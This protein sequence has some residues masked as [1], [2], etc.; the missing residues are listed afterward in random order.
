MA[1]K[2]LVHINGEPLDVE[3]NRDGEQITVRFGDE[4]TWHNVDLQ[5]VFASGLFVLLMD[6]RPI[7]L[8][9]E[10]G[11]RS[12]ARVTVGRHRFE[13]SVERWRPPS[14]RGRRRTLTKSGKIEIKA[15]M[16][17]SIVEVLCAVGDTLEEGDVVM[18]IE[19]M[20]MNN[21]QRS[22]VRGVVTSMRVK[23]GDRVQS[24]A[25]LAELEAIPDEGQETAD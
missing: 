18:V 19:S 2:H 16:T 21:E 22:P 3:V 23:A 15:P 7:E 17:G 9:I 13:T 24:D 1:E 25:V 20:K 11:N 10:P 5:Q 12:S 8:S 6:N 14:S 4:D